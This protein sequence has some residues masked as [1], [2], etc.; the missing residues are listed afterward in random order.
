MLSELA[1]QLGARTAMRLV[2]N[3]ATAQRGRPAPWP[4]RESPTAVAALDELGDLTRWGA[5]QLGAAYA[6]ILDD[7]ARDQGGVYYTPEPIADALVYGALAPRLLDRR[8]VRVL[9]PACG[10]GV[11]L[12]SAAC[13]IAGRSHNIRP[14]VI[15][16]A[17][18]W[19]FALW[20]TFE[21]RTGPGV[22]A[23]I[24]PSAYLH[25]AAYTGLRRRIRQLADT[26]WVIDLTPEGLRPPAETRLWPGVQIPLCITVLARTRATTREPADILHLT[27]AGTATEKTRTVQ[28]ACSAIHHGP[29]GGLHAPQNP[30]PAD[31]P[32]LREEAIPG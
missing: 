18:F 19:R 29:S 15:G 13:L 25:G 1:A 5:T 20:R 14:E 27:A 12:E 16:A 24:T 17:I 22:V 28:A 32:R 23:L 9:D 7:D 26:G 3:R 30:H 2:V 8:T 21:V 10:A 6:Q 11:L 31:L 4:E